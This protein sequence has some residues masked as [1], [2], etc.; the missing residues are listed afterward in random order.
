MTSRR[1]RALVGA[2]AVLAASMLVSASAHADPKPKIH[3]R[4]AKQLSSSGA[5]DFWVRLDRRADLGN[6]STAADWA[7]RGDAV[8][9]ALRQA[10][11]SSQR[12]V[13]ARLDAAKVG[14]E[15]FW[16]TN[17]I[18]VRSGTAELAAELAKKSEVRGLFA[19]TTYALPE[20]TATAE[21]APAAVE[22]GVAAINADDVWQSRGVRGEGIVVANIDSGVQYDHPALAAAYRGNSESGVVNDYNWYDPLAGCASSSP[23]DDNGHGTHTMGTMVGAGGIG[24]APGARWIAAKG[25]SNTGCPDVALVKA[26]Q[27]LLAPTDANGQNPK[28]ALRPHVINNSWGGDNGSVEDPFYDDVIDGWVASGIFPA[29]AVGNA[30][31]ACDTAGSPGDSA[32]A[33]AVGAFDASGAIALFSSR[34]PGAGGA[35]KPDITAPGVNIRS[36]LPGSSYGTANGT[37]MATP[38]VSGAVA[39]LWSA[40]PQLIG[41]VQATEALLDGTAIDVADTLCGGTAG[42]NS[43]WGEGK[44]DILAAITSGPSVDT[45]QMGGA[46]TD[47]A[48]GKPLAGASVRFEGSSTRSIAV[49]SDGGYVAF[50]EV[51]TYKVTVSAYGYETAVATD[52][53]LAKG[54]KLTRDFALAPLPMATVRG[55]VTDVSGQGWPMAATVQVTG[56]P[57]EPVRTDPYTG[58]YSIDLPKGAEYTLQVTPRYPGYLPASRT[59]A[60]GGDMAQDLALAV[61]PV[62]C[63]APGYRHV[64][65]GKVETFDAA[66]EDWTV[67]D[68][69]TG[70]G[71]RFDDPGNRGNLT[72]GTGGFAIVDG[73]YFGSGKTQDSELISPVYDLSQVVLPE[74]VFDTRHNTYGGASASVDYTVDGGQTWTTVWRQTTTAVQGFI[75][76]PLPALAGKQAVQIRFRYKG[77][78]GFWWEVDNA[79]LGARTCSPVD[80]GLLGGRVLDRNTG[81]PA[82]GARVT[83]SD[84]TATTDLDGSYW[85]FSP[86][87]G[88]QQVVAAKD[89]YQPDTRAVEITKGSMTRAD[90]ALS[91]GRIEFAPA[92]VARTVAWGGSATTPLTVTN[93][94]SAPATV[95][96]TEHADNFSLLSQQGAPLHEVTATLSAEAPGKAPAAATGQEQEFVPSA[97]P[98][99]SI[100]DHPVNIQDNAVWLADGKAYSG[101]GYSGTEYLKS[102]YTFDPGKGSWERRA[103][104]TVPR[105]AAGYG[106]IDGRFYVAGGWISD[107]GE[108]RSVEIYNPLTDTWSV[109]AEVPKAYGGVGSAVLDGKLYVIGGCANSCGSTDVFAYDAGQDRWTR[110]APYPE[111]VA[112]LGCGGIDGKVYC[113]GGLVNGAVSARTYA[114]DPDSDAWTRKADRPAG[115][116]GASSA[117]ANGLLLMSGGAVQDR[118]TNVG[119]AYHP[120]SDTWSAMPNANFSMYRSGAGCGF[121]RTGGAPTVGSL[122]WSWSQMLPGFDQ[123]DSSGDVSWLDVDKGEITLAPGESATIAV[124][125]N[126]VKAAMTQPGTLRAALGV[127]TDTPYAARSVPVALTVL[128]PDTWGKITG[129]VT[130]DG[131]PTAGAAVQITGKLGRR[132]VTADAT[133]RYAIWLDKATSPVTVIVTA[134]GYQPE[135]AEAK[136]K[137][138]KTVTVDF[139]LARA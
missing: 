110:V 117:A 78:F 74:V 64:H 45:G 50:L 133:G 17:A 65:G 81:G 21:P 19:P 63:T 106:T 47:A 135:T 39:L 57:A 73:T 137:S 61:D 114:Y 27:W 24:V 91:I 83:T 12:D 32:S 115:V 131:T 94:G 30:G 96:L 111:P 82:A 51:G 104:A 108:T 138:K 26:G 15:P 4:L 34:G 69:S 48:T 134:D 54:E 58:A 44:L 79:S 16:A 84:V 42:D 129:V 62:A 2:V 80:G 55:T 18:Y 6:A 118:V 23:C 85:L 89:H 9:S 37:S 75:E 11:E 103:D 28:P 102:L 33:Y 112:W 128:A 53:T 66:P 88:E 126:A 35:A 122:P 124:S 93:T 87:Y 116:W 76:L 132:T 136:I 31:P 123:C 92:E 5:V 101:F 14:Y 59:V 40:A 70:G 139:Q 3:P 49:L 46:V 7:E 38:H 8:M 97:A 60:V 22:W 98:W 95:T 10:A 41:D 86:A 36:S 90:L 67:K 99:Q 13:R 107:G 20:V 29:F 25:C 72:G 130:S 119:Y 100:A 120:S 113:S 43:T 127:Q 52:L 125:T 68:N 121:F 77:S 109:G 71:W 56:R 105:A 1:I